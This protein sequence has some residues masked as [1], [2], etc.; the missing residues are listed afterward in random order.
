MARKT[1]S[2]PSAPSTPAAPVPAGPARRIPLWGAGVVVAQ[3]ALMLMAFNP[4]AHNGGDTAG[5]VTLAHSLLSRHSYQDLWQPGQAPHMKY[6][7][8]FPALL[9]AA[10][11]L[12][13]RT[14]AALKVIPALFTTLT[15][16]LVYLW[17]RDRRGAPFAAAVALLTAMSNAVLWSSHWELSEP[18]F[19]AL[20]FLAF[21]AYERA[22]GA[23]V[24]PGRSGAEDQGDRPRAHVGRWLATGT[25][26]VG[27]A[28]FTR[29]AGLPLLFA[30]GTWLV[31]HRRWRTLGALAGGVGGLALLWSLRGGQGAQYVSEFW[32]VDPYQ[33]DL[34]RVGVLGLVERVLDNARLY[35]FQ[36]VPIGFTGFR[37]GVPAALLGILLFA[38]AIWGWAR[39]LRQRPGVAEL[40]VP[41]YLGLILLWP[42]V[43]SGDRFALPLMPLMLFYAGEV[44][45]DVTTTRAPKLRAAAAGLAIAL[46]AMPALASWTTQ[47]RESTRCAELVKRDGAFAC[48]GPRTYEFVEAA[49]WSAAHLPEG[50]V[51]LT[52]KPRIWYV[53]SGQPSETFPFTKDAN[54]FLAFADSVGA[55]YVVMDYMDAAASVYVAQALVDKGGAFCAIES[56]SQGTDLPTQILGI[57]PPDRRPAA[58]AS[59]AADGTVTIA[60]KLCPP[61]MLR[62][63]PLPDRSP[64][65]QRIPLLTGFAASP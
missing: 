48:W 22:L 3:L 57:M 8:V 20:T 65:T 27:L 55:R 62:G 64:R 17:A 9:A 34:G 49:V 5:Y 7:P 58:E 32:M 42:A 12:G 53:E 61:A 59:T 37:P 16:G 21:W 63:Q 45:L 35:V 60:M 30:A 24:P 6:P 39:R 26:A 46:L 51:V 36:Y 50:A 38:V 28:Y 54:R 33:P 1:R 56:F 43:W 29:S 23:S 14:W 11:A 19:M 4:A 44:L 18:P 47:V 15:V 40:F 52:R 2:R 10:I 25:V 13:A 41:M 31:R